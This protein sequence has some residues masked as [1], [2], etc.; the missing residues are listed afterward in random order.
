MVTKI[1]N[2]KIY[3][4]LKLLSCEE[5]LRDGHFRRIVAQNVSCH[6]RNETATLATPLFN[7]NRPWYRVAVVSFA[8]MTKQKID[9]N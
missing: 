4:F 7:R 8:G 6:G 2:S 3:F 1:E 9:N 5:V